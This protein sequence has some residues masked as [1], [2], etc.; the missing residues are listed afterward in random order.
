[1]PFL[2]PGDGNFRNPNDCSS[3]Y[4]CANRIPYRI[5]CSGGL[6]FNDMT[7]TCDW[8]HMVP[9]CSSRGYKK[10][11]L[12]DSVSSMAEAAMTKKTRDEEIVNEDTKHMSEEEMESERVPKMKNLRV[13][14]DKSMGNDKPEKSEDGRDIRHWLRNTIGEWTIKSTQTPKEEVRTYIVEPQVTTA[15][16]QA[17]TTARSILSE[18]IDPEYRDQTS[19]ILP[20]NDES[21]YAEEKYGRQRMSQ[22]IPE[23][24]GRKTKGNISYLI[25]SLEE[26]SYLGI[27]YCL[28]QIILLKL[29]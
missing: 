6:V 28:L 29:Q 11:F 4:Q 25:L 14:N 3:F 18:V 1:M 9:E 15:V 5:Y 21:F 10:S 26:G 24:H 19:E 23:K 12:S 27:T 13:S 20:P 7:Q 22:I 2:C 8:P 16:Y 17:G